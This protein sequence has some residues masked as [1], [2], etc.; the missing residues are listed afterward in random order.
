MK[1]KIR[2]RSAIGVGIDEL[3]DDI[4]K[5]RELAT[6]LMMQSGYVGNFDDEEKKLRVYVFVKCEQAEAMLDVARKMNFRTAGMIQGSVFV[7]NLELNRPHLK[8]AS[9]YSFYKELYK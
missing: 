7:S 1:E 5:A 2:I 3:T 9:K 6:E 8:Y 4:N